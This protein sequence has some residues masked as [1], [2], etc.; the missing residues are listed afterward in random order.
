MPLLSII[1]AVDEHFAIGKNNQ[2]L[3]HLKSDLQRFKQLTLNHAV[4][5]GKHTFLSLPNG[6]LPRRTNIVLTSTSFSP[7]G[8][9][10]VHSLTEALEAV[11]NEE[12]VF[13]IGG[14]SFWVYIILWIAIPEAQTSVEKLQMK[15]EQVNIDNIEKKIVV[16]ILVEYHYQAR[17]I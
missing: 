12:E 7:T 3:C 2:L 5:M 17:R 10:V 1:A 8:V 15:G 11:K 9:I 14:S 4:I 16:E 6:A 13:I